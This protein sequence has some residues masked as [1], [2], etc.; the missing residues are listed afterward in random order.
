MRLRIILRVPGLLASL[1]QFRTIDRLSIVPGSR[2]IFKRDD[3]MRKLLVTATDS[4]LQPWLLCC[5]LLLGANALIVAQ[6]TL[7]RPGS[8]RPVSLTRPR[9]PPL[10]ESQWTESHRQTLAKYAA[11][12]RPGNDLRT[13]VHIPALVDGTMPFQDYITRQSSLSPRHRE[14]LILRTAVAPQ[15]QFRVVAAR[16][17]REEGWPD[18]GGG[19]S[20]RG[21]PECARVEPF[22]GDAPGFRGSVVPKLSGE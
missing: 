8:Q 18:P 1:E 3:P 12:G 2:T 6:I 9:I 17:N 5:A 15:Q 20:N 16:P 22:R 19:A 14:V 7:E 11:D 21:G 13:L 10:P 4:S